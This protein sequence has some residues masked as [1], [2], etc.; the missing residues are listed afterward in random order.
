[1]LSY[2]IDNQRIAMEASTQSTSC[3]AVAKRLPD[4]DPTSPAAARTKKIAAVYGKNSLSF[5]YM[6]TDQAKIEAITIANAQATVA[7]TGAQ[8]RSSRPSQD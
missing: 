3:R 6:T 2:L 4:P 8:P 1:M 7:A 5:Q